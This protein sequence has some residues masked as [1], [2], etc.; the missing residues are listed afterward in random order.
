MQVRSNRLQDFLKQH[1]APYTLVPHAP[2]FSSQA[3]AAKIHI[4]GADMAKTVVLQGQSQTY[5]AVLPASRYV[6]LS[7]FGKIVGEAVRLATE[8][9]IRG[10]FPDCELGAIPPFGK[11]YGVRTYVDESL[12]GDRE[13]VFTAGGHSDAM[14]M[15][16]RDFQGLSQP[17]ICS[18]ATAGGRQ[19]PKTTA[20]SER[21]H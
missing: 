20:P 9:H 8:E 17:E 10:L 3:T 5:L 7:R 18:F 6:D 16:Y 12:T 1:P 4:S 11:L 15:N 13:I 2:T 19:P 21:V 14:R